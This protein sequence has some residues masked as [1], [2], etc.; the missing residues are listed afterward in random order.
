MTR[1]RLALV[2]L[3]ALLPWAAACSDK[4]SQAPGWKED[5]TPPTVTI[6]A[7]EPGPVSGIVELVA[8]AAD[9]GGIATVDWKV[10]GGILGVPD[11]SPPYTHTWNT[12]AYGPGIFSWTAV[13]RDS[14]G[15]TT[16]SA[17]VTYTVS[18]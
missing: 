17:G 11:S 10:N 2:A 15:N 5:A 18:P 13:A 3:A 1:P 12:G 9:A 6:V 8:E 14:A 16:E 4:S 7:P